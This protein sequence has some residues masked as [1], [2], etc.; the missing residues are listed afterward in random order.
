ML[1]ASS[2]TTKA[3]SDSTFEVEP[4][5]VQ[6]APFSS[7]YA[8]VSFNPLTMTSYSSYFEATLE[9]MPPS[10]KTRSIA[11]EISGEG[12][13]PRFTIQ[14]PSL[15]NKK[16]QCLMLFKRTIINT[17]DCQQLVLSNDGTLPTKVNFF[18]YDPDQAFKL[19]PL[20]RD[21]DKSYENGI[22]FN[23]NNDMVSSVVIQPSSQVSFM[24]VCAP[25]SIQTYQ[26]SL[27]LTVTDNQ[28]EDTL[29]QMVGEGYMEDVVF[30]NL[31]SLVGTSEI[32]DDVMADEEVSALKC[33]AISFGDVYVNDKKQLLFTM[34]N[35]SK[36]DCFRFEWPLSSS[37]AST[38]M[39]SNNASGVI[40]NQSE[41]NMTDNGST[42]VTFLPRVGHLHAGCAKDITVTFKSTDTKI[43]R[44]ELFSCQLTKLIFEQSIN[45]V[46]DWDDRMTMVKWINEYAV[47]G[48]SSI[49]ELTQSMVT[50]S[51]RQFNDQSAVNLPGSVLQGNMSQAT[52]FSTKQIIR[53]KIVEVEPEPR[54]TR[55]DE[56]VQPM[57]LFISANCDYSKYKCKT[58][59]IRFK[60]TLMFQTRVYE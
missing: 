52:Q 9:N 37:S 8:T 31:H 33:N 16:G 28:F 34:K 3:Y 11:F 55:S 51:Q 47:S 60:D 42:A 49:N 17:T 4:Q 21:N 10:A 2:K 19:K 27:Q 56:A 22:V 15:R 18:L 7:T 24:V 12:N 58:N 5:R 39:T 29:V 32:E 59:A 25:H 40:Q 45:D 43:L 53:K 20:V 54:H 44:K 57:E 1:K 14:K 46:K 48:S 23:L 35:Q 6:I 26:A 41:S 30:E 36:S 50:S 38:G 13:L